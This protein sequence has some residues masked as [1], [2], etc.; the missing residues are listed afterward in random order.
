MKEFTLKDKAKLVGI[1]ASTLRDFL[2]KNSAPS[3]K[4]RQK[5]NKALSVLC[6]VMTVATPIEKT[7]KKKEKTQEKP[8]M[9]KRERVTK[10]KQETPVPKQKTPTGDLDKE[11]IERRMKNLD[12]ATCAWCGKKL[13]PMYSKKRNNWFAGCVGYW[14]RPCCKFTKDLIA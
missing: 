7:E 8:M 11:E 2:E 12:T 4:T 13:V 3:K 6:T 5:I 1:P 9:L 14:T 10:I